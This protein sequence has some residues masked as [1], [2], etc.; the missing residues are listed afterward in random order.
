M[1]YK[2]IKLDNGMTLLMEKMDTV[3]SVALGIWVRTGSRDES[4]KE[5]GISH[6]LEHMFFK[7]TRK[8]SARDIAIAMDSL[9]G[10]LNAFTTK[11]G[12]TFYIKVLDDFLDKGVELLSDIFLNPIF[13]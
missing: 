4:A 13:L 11:E 2:K 12:T 1:N 3:R 7:G 8:R 6:F 9:G 10:E 5:A